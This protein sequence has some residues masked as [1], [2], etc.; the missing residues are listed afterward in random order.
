MTRDEAREYFKK[1]AL[2]YEDITSGDICV[3]IMMLNKS[4][5]TASEYGKTSV[6]NLR[7]SEKI[8]VKYNKN[9]SIKN[10]F[11][12]VNGHS[13]VRRE[14]ISFNTDGF[15]GFAGWADE[16]NVKPMIEAFIQWCDYLVWMKTKA[17]SN[18]KT[19]KSQQREFKFR[20]AIPWA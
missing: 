12:Y 14:C 18:G 15:I 10:C 9:G 13:F 11:L 4:V 19:T 5:K 8:E 7:L 20:E 16:S 2:F 3:L 17:I 6:S 1:H